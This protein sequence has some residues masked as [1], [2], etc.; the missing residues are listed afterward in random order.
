MTP[1]EPESPNTNIESPSIKSQLPNVSDTSTPESGVWSPDDYNLWTIHFFLKPFRIIFMR[2][3]WLGR[4]LLRSSKIMKILISSQFSQKESSAIFHFS[5]FISMLANQKISS[6]H[7][8]KF[9]KS[10][11]HNA[12]AAGAIYWRNSNK[13]CWFDCKT[14][15]KHCQGFYCPCYMGHTVWPIHFR[16]TYLRSIQYGPYNSEIKSEIQKSNEEYDKKVFIT[17]IANNIDWFCFIIFFAAT[18][19]NFSN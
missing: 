7:A 4:R 15:G 6:K 2:I 16:P 9:N 11:T 10:N 3:Q 17:N 13:R 14:N 12:Q 5:M 18:I 8:T 19:G 1:P